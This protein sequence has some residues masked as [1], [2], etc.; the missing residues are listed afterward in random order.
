MSIW[1]LAIRSLRH[2]RRT[3][4]ALLFGVAIGAAVLTGALIVGD[5]VRG[6]LKGLTL[7][8]LGRISEILMGEQFFR[9]E[10]AASLKTDRYSEIVPAILINQATVETQGASVSRVRGVTVVG[11]SETFWDLSTQGRRPKTPQEDEIVINETLA[12]ELGA[13]LGDQLLIRVGKP[14]GIAA[15]SPLARKDNLVKT[16]VDL[17][18]IDIVPTEGLARFSLQ[19]SQQLPVNAFVSLA[20][21]QDGLDQDGKI[22]AVLVAT[23]DAA[24]PGTEEDFRYLQASLEPTL[25]DLGLALDRVQLSY[26]DNGEDK[27]VFEYDTFTNVRMIFARDND[28]ALTSVVHEHHGQPVFTYLATQM[29]KVDKSGTPSGSIVPYS[30]ITAIDSNT[31]MGPLFE[32]DKPLAMKDDGIVLNRWTAE[33]MEAQ[34]GDTIRVTYFEPETTHGDIEEF[35]ANFTVQ[36]IAELTQPDAP[37]RRRRDAVYTVPP[38]RINDPHLT[39]VVEGITDA[40]TID[41][42][43]APFPMN[44]KLLRGQDDTYWEDYRTT[45]KAFVSLAK[46]RELWS[47]RFGKTT[48]YRL[49]VGDIDTEARKQEITEAL[50]ESIESF[51]M[52][53]IRAKAEGL[54][55][56]R[57]TTPFDA[58][59]FGFSM[60]IIASALMLVS[61]LLRLN[62]EHRASQAGLLGALGFSPRRTLQLFVTENAIIAMAGSGVGVVLGVGYAALMLAGLRTWWVDAVAV[63]FMTVTITGT[64]LGVGFA[65]GLATAMAT[66]VITLLRLR[67]I[68]LSQL[69]VGKTDTTEQS[70]SRGKQR[71]WIRI[72]PWFLFVAALAMGIAAPSLPP[73]PQGGAFFGCG[74]CVLIAI[75]LFVNGA[76]GRRASESSDGAQ[77]TLVTL[78]IRNLT[79]SP[80]RSALTIGLV[81]AACFLIVAISAFRLAPTEEGTGGFEFIGES[82][83][84]I[85]AFDEGVPASARLFPL[86]LQDGDDASCR[87]LFQSSQPQ[88]IG[89]TDDFIREA[90]SVG[91]ME[92]A[93]TAPTEQGVAGWEILG[94]G[95]ADDVIPVVLDKNTAMYGMQLYGG[96]G[97]EFERDYGTA[98]VLRFRI[99]GLLSGSI[100][101][102][103][104]LVH[105]QQLLRNFERV[106]GY[107]FFLVDTPAEEKDAVRTAL[108]AYYGDEGLDLTD[109][110]RL[111]TELLAVQNTYLSTFQSLGG[112]GLLLGTLGLAAVQLRN[113]LQRRGELALLRAT[114][115]RNDQ[116]SFLLLVEHAMLLF[117]GLAVGTL[118][119]IVVVLPH[120]VFGGASIPIPSLA[121]TLALIG[122]TGFV[123]AIAAQRSLQKTPLL[124]ALRGD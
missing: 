59:F 117:G 55:A 40:E 92:W 42:W 14:T 3:N 99:V 33:D 35:S 101:Q 38:T 71:R 31:T 91:Q 87:N 95:I 53:W 10:L 84:A 70:A 112:L 118:S 32:G 85:F 62:L 41:R 12:Q 37:Y 56:S 115:Y 63:P 22:N 105:E 60:F 108:E 23:Q 96:V 80:T 119:A 72:A 86:R 107:R 113:V 122:V 4:L 68:P 111:L 44:R 93:A 25:E 39:P 28:E 20:T 54:A 6:S 17:T 51:G 21:L 109:S 47:S 102:G 2:F 81:A 79:R 7:E 9:E 50:T 98:G 65:L 66:I 19:A 15:D 116:L 76:L 11:T 77:L 48:S 5:S 88:I 16:M 106:G 67:K 78:A 90:A 49:P 45:P 104:M 26:R 57:G 120:Y 27:V 69:M 34:V 1:T 24:T 83:Q 52:H 89:I 36:A 74:S 82:D 114:G 13:K 29:Q 124:P 73:E 75:L 61:L 110:Q 64:A 8:R 97:S 18:L 58:L 121:I 123:S 46:G 30:T 100:F 43:D 103:S 94:Q